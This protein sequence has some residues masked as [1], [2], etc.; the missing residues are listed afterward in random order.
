MLT[1]ETFFLALTCKTLY[2]S[3]YNK[4]FAHFVL[5]SAWMLR[6]TPSVFVKG[7]PP[8]LSIC[9]LSGCHPLRLSPIH[10]VRD[11]FPLLPI[12]PLEQTLSGGPLSQWNTLTCPSSKDLSFVCDGG[13]VLNLCERGRQDRRGLLCHLPKVCQTAKD[14]TN[15]PCCIVHGFYPSTCIFTLEG[16]FLDSSGEI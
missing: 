9:H 6:L 4:P 8:R 16:A 5:L 7:A 10:F 13:E 14:L 3:L 15:A 11:L 2:D 1:K 12:Y